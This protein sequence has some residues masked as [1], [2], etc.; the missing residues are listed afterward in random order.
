MTKSKDT[1]EHEARIKLIEAAIQDF[2]LD[3]MEVELLNKITP[4]QWEKF[5]KKSKFMSFNLVSLADTVGYKSE[6]TLITQNKE[7]TDHNYAMYSCVV[8]TRNSKKNEVTHP[9]LKSWETHIKTISK[10]ILIK[11]QTILQGILTTE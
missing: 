1:S 10:Y 3:D 9:S 11:P 5:A 4:L 6:F 8:M 2:S 7:S